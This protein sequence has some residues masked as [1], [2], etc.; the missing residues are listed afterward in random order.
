M[1]DATTGYETLSF[2]DGF[3]GY[4]QIRIVLSDEEMTTFRTLKGV[5]CYKVMSFRLKN[6]GITY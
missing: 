6:V 2:I 5:Y 4:N 3:S 1:V